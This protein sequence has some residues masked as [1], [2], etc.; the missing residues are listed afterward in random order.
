MYARQDDLTASSS[1]GFTGKFTIKP[2]VSLINR[3][4]L[5][6]APAS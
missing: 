3:M 5:V 2:E 1:Y 6:Y 4:I